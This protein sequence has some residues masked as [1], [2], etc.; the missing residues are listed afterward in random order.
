MFAW[1]IRMNKAEI[2]LLARHAL[3]EKYLKLYILV[4]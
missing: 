4:G 3:I 1:I 2:G